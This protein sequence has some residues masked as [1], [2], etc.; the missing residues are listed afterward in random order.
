MDVRFFSYAGFFDDILG[1]TTLNFFLRMSNLMP[2]ASML[3]CIIGC[4]LNFDL[5]ESNTKNEQN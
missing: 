4:T 1:S 5:M 2:C 3:L